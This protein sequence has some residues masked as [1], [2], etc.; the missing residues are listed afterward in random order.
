MRLKKAHH[1]RRSYEAKCALAWRC[2][3]SVTFSVFC[4]VRIVWR[5]RCDPTKH[6]HTTAF[7]LLLGL[8]CLGH[9]RL[10]CTVVPC[11]SVCTPFCDVNISPATPTCLCNAQVH[12]AIL[13]F[14]PTA[15]PKLLDSRVIPL[16]L[17][18]AE[19]PNEDVSGACDVGQ[20]TSICRTANGEALFVSFVA[21]GIG[22]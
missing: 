20:R 8:L 21:C 7:A 4:V 2:F 18:G 13:S 12:D 6:L 15:L 10:V 3:R 9:V 1:V 5:V 14:G 19:S 17:R 11:L 16:A 22:V